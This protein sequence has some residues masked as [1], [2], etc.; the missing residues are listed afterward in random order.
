MSQAHTAPPFV[1]PPFSVIVR[2][3]WQELVNR[4]SQTLRESPIKLLA[5]IVF[6]LLIWL[7]LFLFFSGVF[8]RIY[9]TTLEG[10]VAI[11]M[12]F[13]FFFV[14]LMV[15]LTFSNAILAHGSLFNRLESSYLF[16][17]PIRPAHVVL[18]KFFEGLVLSSWS[19]ILL[20]IPLMLAMASRSDSWVFYPYFVGYFLCFVPIPAAV[21]LF[22]AWA[23]AMWFPAGG[24]RL[25]IAAAVLIAALALT[26]LWRVWD[27]TTTSQTN[28]IKSFYAQMALVE[29]ALWPSTWV[30][31]GIY[32][33]ATRRLGDAGFYLY[34]TLANALFLSYV[35]V[36][37]VGA[38]ALTA[39]SRAQT[40]GD[41]VAV[42][43]RWVAAALTQVLFF[44]LPHRLRQVA[45]KDLQ[46]FMRDPLQWSQ[47]AILFGLMTIYIVNIPQIS[48]LDGFVA[49]RMLVAYLNFSA[50]CLI[51]ATFTS[52]FIYPM[53]SL[54]GHQLW[55]IGLLPMR[56]RGLVVAK[57]AFALTVTGL[58]AT[59][60]MAL[61][62]TMLD[63][64]VR[65]T[66]AQLVV[67]ASVCFGLCGLS[68]G[69]GARFPLFEQQNPT[70]I[71]SGFGGT[72]NLIVSV[73][74]VVLVLVAVGVVSLR[75][76]RDVGP[77]LDVRGLGAYAGVIA[78]GLGVGIAAL[79]AG[80]RHF[81][82]TE[83]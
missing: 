40:G 56:R 41:A 55:L 76:H 2:L 34:L 30:S 69:L 53:I 66:L 49:N 44:Y 50:I 73:L 26:W 29:S 25:L 46:T 36:R 78:L 15:M 20:G 9:Q 27:A 43:G 7:S 38:H 23:V 24:R 81:E 62:A 32:A 80:A 74:Y 82:R 67:M 59:G 39:Y 8:D 10:V 18:L 22:A 3:R 17:S 64:P 16:A 45:L 79:T 54:E 70:R 58:C 11:P 21:G 42:R 13:K 83:I 6:V 14:A 77:V 75:F 5:A 47:L 28:W 19:L 31:H 1:P 72:I 35:V 68:V 37:F 4:A 12:V 61:S 57:F 48:G 65:W 51:L 52:R 33:A 63:L 71:A 60:V